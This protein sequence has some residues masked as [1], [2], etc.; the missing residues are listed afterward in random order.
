MRRFA[1]FRQPELAVERVVGDASRH[2]PARL[3]AHHVL[4]V[5]AGEGELAGQ[6]PVRILVDHV[7]DEAG[8][9]GR[10]PALA[11]TAYAGPEARGKALEAG[12]D[13]QISKPVVPAELVAQAAL[14]AGVRRKR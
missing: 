2:L 5:V 14:L 7:A 4:V 1:D 8:K 11:L 13:L 9:G 3:I 10:I 6:M 12:F